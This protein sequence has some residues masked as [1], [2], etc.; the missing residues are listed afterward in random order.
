[1]GA[2]YTKTGDKGKT[3]L[4]GGS[5]VSKDDLRVDCYG[6]FDEANAM[7][8]VAYSNIEDLDMKKVIRDIQKDLFTLSAELASDSKGREKLTSSIQKIDIEAT[9]HLID[10]YTNQLEKLKAFV[11]PGETPGSSFL[12][13]S[14]TIVRRAERSLI[15]LQ[16]QETVR[17]EIT[18]YT[19]RLSDLLFILARVESELLNVQS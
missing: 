19:N 18:Q 12:H 7:L 8:G 17:K 4:L 11:I 5:R 13:V 2:I 9:E 1:M 6:I 15:K 16:K 10:D 14:R 3:A